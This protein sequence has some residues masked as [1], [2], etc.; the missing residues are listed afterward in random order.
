MLRL[1]ILALWLSR[2]ALPATYVVIFSIMALMPS[3]PVMQRLDPGRQ[4]LLGSAWM[5]TR[6]LSFLLL[7]WGTWWHTRPRALLIAAVVMLVTFFGVTVRPSDLFGNGSPTIDLASMLVAQLILGAALGLI[8]SSSLYFGMVLSDGS[9]QHGG[10]HEALI[11]LGFILGPGTGALAETV[12]PG[13]LYSSIAAVGTV[14]LLSVIAVG[15]TSVLAERKV[16][17]ADR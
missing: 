14:V 7:G 6:W 4:T 16:R 10:Y 8:Y 5:A 11:G 1:R 15:V 17:S 12:R 2:V 9:T 3:L 13:S